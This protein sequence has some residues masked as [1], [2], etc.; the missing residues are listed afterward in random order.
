MS[1]CAYSLLVI[2]VCLLQFGCRKALNEHSA[3]TLL[4]EGIRE[5]GSRRTYG[6]NLSITAGKVNFNLAEDNGYKWITTSRLGDELAGLR[7]PQNFPIV[8]ESLRLVNNGFIARHEANR[9]YYVPV[10]VQG[11]FT[12]SPTPSGSVARRLEMH[13]R[14]RPLDGT[15]RGDWASGARGPI[16]VCQGSIN[17]NVRQDGR[18]EMALDGGGCLWGGEP[19]HTYTVQNSGR[20]TNLISDSINAGDTLRIALSG[21]TPSPISIRWINYEPTARLQQHER[22]SAGWPHIGKINVMSV[23]NPLLSDTG[24]SAQ[25]DFTWNILIDDDLGRSVSDVVDNVVREGTVTFAKKPDGQWVVDH[26]EFS[27][28]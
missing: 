11:A 6:P 23:S 26:I 3:Q 27:G 8:E 20:V 17:G 4:E 14:L 18:I 5:D 13:L 16:G 22:D 12:V 21:P 2:L 24:S 9:E 19:R 15:V 28:S 10:T 25:A 1:R 7:E